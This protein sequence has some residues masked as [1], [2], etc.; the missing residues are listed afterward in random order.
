[1]A[2]GNTW[3]GEKHLVQTGEE[4]TIEG[5]AVFSGLVLFLLLYNLKINQRDKYGR[6]VLHIAAFQGTESYVRIAYLGKL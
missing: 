3:K 5:A 6:T 4:G 2:L 1:V